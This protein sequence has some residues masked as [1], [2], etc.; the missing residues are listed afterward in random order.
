MENDHP[1]TDAQI[2]E[3]WPGSD[4]AEIRRQFDALMKQVTL[5]APNAP[6]PRF[7]E[8][9]ANV[10]AGKSKSLPQRIADLQA[11][12][13]GLPDHWKQWQWIADPRQSF[14]NRYIRSI[15]GNNGHGMGRQAIATVSG[16][17]SWYFG[18]LADFIAAANPDTICMLLARIAEAEAEIAALKV[19]SCQR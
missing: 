17:E 16:S 15:V 2:S 11:A 12:L 8:T 7:P 3:F 1:L 4:P 10:V 14:G 9:M 18:T 19:D 13:D 5:K 6:F